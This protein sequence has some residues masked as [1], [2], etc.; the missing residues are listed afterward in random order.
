MV[1]SSALIHTDPTKALEVSSRGVVVAQESGNRAVATFLTTIMSRVMAH[2]GD[3]VKALDQLTVVF[4]HY[5]DGGNL[6]N[7]RSGFAILMSVLDHM[8][9][10]VATA[11]IGGFAVNPFILAAIP[12][13]EVAL[14]HAR[15]SLGDVQFEALRRNGAAMTTPAM[16]EFVEN[17]IA[18]VRAELTAT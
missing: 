5:L 12:E 1:Y 2:H 16:V 10:H 8:G 9:R 17:E 3:P 13:T 18:S 14:T 6:S 11:T 7:L 4:R 15:E